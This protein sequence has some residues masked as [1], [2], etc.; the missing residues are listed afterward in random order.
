M[1]KN[2]I[3]VRAAAL[4]ILASLTSCSSTHSS[5][6]SGEQI[7][8]RAKVVGAYQFDQF[9]T[10]NDGKVNL[11]EWK[12]GLTLMLK[13]EDKD[14]NGSFESKKGEEVHCDWMI[15]AN[16]N[17]DDVISSSEVNEGLET[18]FKKASGTDSRISRREFNTFSWITGEP[19]AIRKYKK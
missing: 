19:Y 11:S 18:I 16:K 2:K 17:G 3:L 10:S 8:K 4:L 14:D 5:S 15:N 7:V 9:D 12:K 6:N 1:I 13:A